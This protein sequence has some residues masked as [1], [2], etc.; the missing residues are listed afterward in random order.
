MDVYNMELKDLHAPFCQVE[1]P[2]VPQ[3]S[4]S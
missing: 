1:V 2:L 4:A 3:I